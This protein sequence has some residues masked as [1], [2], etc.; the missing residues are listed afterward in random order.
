MFCTNCGAFNGEDAEL[1]V[2]CR[3]PLGD[4]QTE[5]KPTRPRVFSDRWLTKVDFLHSLFDFS[6]NQFVSL[7]MVKFLY[8]LS[9][10]AAGWI[11]LFLIIAGFKTSTW[12]GMFALLI[13]AP[14]IFLITVISSRIFLEMILSIFRM[15]DHMANIGMDSPN[16]K[17]ESRDGIQWNV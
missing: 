1:C 16:E 17:P 9:T 3:E 2:N 11:A 13:G 15:A 6:F 12:F 5:E 10:L 14:V 7:K 8:S 4:I